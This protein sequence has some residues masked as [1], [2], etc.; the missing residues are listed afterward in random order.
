MPDNTLPG[1][2]EDFMQSIMPRGDQLWDHSVNSV[3]QIPAVDGTFRF[4]ATAIRKAEVH[5]WLAWQDE[6]GWPYGVALTKG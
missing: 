3:A 5:T 4:P 1:A 2:L 6:P